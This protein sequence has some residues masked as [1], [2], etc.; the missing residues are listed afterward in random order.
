MRSSRRKEAQTDSSDSPWRL[1][2]SRI[3]S[4]PRHLDC[5]NYLF[6]DDPRLPTRARTHIAMIIAASRSGTASPRTIIAASRRITTSSPSIIAGSRTTTGPPSF[7]P[8]GS[9]GQDSSSPMKNF[10]RGCPQVLA[11]GVVLQPNSDEIWVAH[12]FSSAPTT[13]VVRSDSRTWW[14]NCA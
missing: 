10:L 6:S 4:E 7:T 5:C 3:G 8:G 11:K 1:T 13:C 12:P 14:G 2:T 9:P